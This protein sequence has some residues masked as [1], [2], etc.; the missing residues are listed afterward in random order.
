LSVKAIVPVGIDVAPD[1][2]VTVAVKITDWLS[3]GEEGDAATVTEVAP[4][5]TV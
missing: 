2:K 3:V 4:A 1:G 5:F